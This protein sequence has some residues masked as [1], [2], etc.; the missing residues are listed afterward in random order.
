MGGEHCPPLAGADVTKRK[1]I[2][3]TGHPD[4]DVAEPAPGVE[5]TVEELELGRLRWKLSKAE[6][7]DQRHPDV[8]A[9]RKAIRVLGIGA[10]GGLAKGS[11]RGNSPPSCALALPVCRER[12]CVPDKSMATDVRAFS[13]GNYRPLRRQSNSGYC[14]LRTHRAG[15]ELGGHRISSSGVTPS[16]GLRIRPAPLSTACFQKRVSPPAPRRGNG[17]S[18]AA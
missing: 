10:T 9:G 4:G 17:S 18:R 6:S 1:S 13:G 5:P 15:I 7:G 14:G 11:W 8:L 12:S 3:L 2:A 16:S